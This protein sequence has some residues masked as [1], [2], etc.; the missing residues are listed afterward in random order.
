ML[1][2]DIEE[3]A[4]RAND[5]LPDTISELGNLPEKPTEEELEVEAYPLCEIVE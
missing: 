5:L 3:L 2:V 4:V 1:I